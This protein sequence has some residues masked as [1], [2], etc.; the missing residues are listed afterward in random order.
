MKCDTFNDITLNPN[1]DSIVQS[2]LKLLVQIF[3]KLLKN[4]KCTSGGTCGA[5]ATSRRRGKAFISG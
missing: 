1:A 2:V 3:T 5:A 4:Q